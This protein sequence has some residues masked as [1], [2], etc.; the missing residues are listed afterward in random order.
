MHRLNRGDGRRDDHSSVLKKKEKEE[1]KN[2]STEIAIRGAFNFNYKLHCAFIYVSFVAVTFQDDHRT[3]V[4][5][6]LHCTTKVCSIDG[7]D[8]IQ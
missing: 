2:C 1:K 5:F 8:V 6:F 3:T 4:V 7:F